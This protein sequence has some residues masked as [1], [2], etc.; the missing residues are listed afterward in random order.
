MST[1][2]QARTGQLIVEKIVR[3][4]VYESLFWKEHCPFL[5][6]ETILDVIVDRVEYIGGCYGGNQKSTPFLCLFLKIC[7]LQPTPAVLMEYVRQSDFKYLTCL[8]LLY[9]RMTA[10]PLTIYTILEPF[11]VDRRK[12]RVRR[13]DGRYMI[14][15]MDEFVDRLLTEERFHDIILPKLSKRELLEEKSSSVGE[16]WE[17][18]CSE[19]AESMFAL[20]VRPSFGVSLD[21]EDLPDESDKD[22]DLTSI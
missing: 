12:L 5:D 3:E 10:L 18:F 7:Q 1:K 4:R 9:I 16:G 6:A 2:E 19:K 21:D 13:S 15:Y 17:I 20:S 11:L 8:A 22:P 14:T